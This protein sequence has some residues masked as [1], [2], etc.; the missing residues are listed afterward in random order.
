LVAPKRCA[1][2]DVDVS[3]A[4]LRRKSLSGILAPFALIASALSAASEMTSCAA[5]QNFSESATVRREELQ[6]K[7]SLRQPRNLHRRK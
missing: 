1:P 6:R 5:Q 4:L 2:G 7:K 3:T